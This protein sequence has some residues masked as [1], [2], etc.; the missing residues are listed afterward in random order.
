MTPQQKYQNSP[1]G[2]ATRRAGDLRRRNENREKYRAKDRAFA[3][4]NPDKIRGYQLKMRYGI[5][6]EDWNAIFTAQGCACALCGTT[7]P[8]KR[9]WATDHDHE[10]GSVRGILCHRC[11]LLLGWLGDT[12]PKVADFSKR[13]FEYVGAVPP[14]SKEPP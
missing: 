14:V 11:N 5:T 10:T 6:L 1:K 4:R 8:G 13:I 12:A 2:R 7:N 9:R 3:Q